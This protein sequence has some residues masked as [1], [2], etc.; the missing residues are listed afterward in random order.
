M[1]NEAV[2]FSLVPSGPQYKPWNSVQLVVYSAVT[3]LWNSVT[4]QC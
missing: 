2:D 4:P 3:N 1:K